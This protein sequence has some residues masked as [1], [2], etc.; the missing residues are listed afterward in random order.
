MTG[1]RFNIAVEGVPELL[2]RLRAFDRR[3]A[4]KNLR[5][6]I[7]LAARLVLR[8]ARAFAL[9]PRDTGSLRKSLGVKIRSYRGGESIVGIVGARKDTGKDVARGRIRHT[10]TVTGG[11]GAVRKIVPANYVHFVEL[12]TRPHA[13]GKGSTLD[14]MRRG[15]LVRGKG[16][17]G[18][19][20][21][22][23]PARPFLKPAYQA[24]KS[25]IETT[26][27]GQL[28]KA[29]EEVRA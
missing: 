8:T 18:R 5:R 7:E 4:R 27:R 15:K 9:G 29:I 24:N 10:R 6:G 23:S 25:A 14:R 2:G 28:L 21:P 1:S 19:R 17:F 3:Y 16:Q 12:G 20:H 11:R 26:I 13:L 22:G